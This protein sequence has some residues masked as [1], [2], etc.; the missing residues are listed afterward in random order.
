MRAI[1]LAWH[2]TANVRKVHSLVKVPCAKDGQL[3]P[4]ARQF[5]LICLR[6]IYLAPV[7]AMVQWLALAL[8]V[9]PLLVF[10]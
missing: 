5:K 7:T 9:V 6:L 1:Y 4:L 2:L 3:R 8:F 10:A